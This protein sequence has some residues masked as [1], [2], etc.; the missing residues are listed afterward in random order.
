METSSISGITLRE[1][2]RG[3]GVLPEARHVL[4][5]APLSTERVT[6][7]IHGFNVNMED[8]KRSY[9]AFRES[10]QTATGGR[11]FG[12]IC[13]VFW[14]GDYY[15]HRRAGWV[16]TLLSAATYP[17]AVV[18]AKR[19][20]EVLAK[21]IAA[22]CSA[23]AELHF[24]CHSLGNRVLLE[25]IANLQRLG[26]GAIASATL[27]A[28]A[29]PV[30]A[31]AD[32]GLL[33]S[34][35]RPGCG[36]SLILHSRWDVILRYTFP[37]GTMPEAGAYWSEPVGLHGNPSITWAAGQTYLMPRYGHGHYWPGCESAERVAHMFGYAGTNRLPENVLPSNNVTTRD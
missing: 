33:A 36:R 20:G 5:T 29:V 25:T 35:A 24:I 23:T 31:V 15:D 8:A 28:A 19:C 30:D 1:A 18:K 9:A 34:A 6:F 17:L 12:Q 2:D 4:G 7:L 13:D 14:P 16:N 32:G 11:H 21:Y 22:H 10:L 26:R 3:G 27:M 37:L